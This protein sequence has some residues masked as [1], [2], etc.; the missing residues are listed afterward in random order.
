MKAARIFVLF[1]ASAAAVAQNQPAQTASALID[2][3]QVEPAQKLARLRLQEQPGDAEALRV[4]GR[5]ML[6]NGDTEGAV[7]TL[8]EAAAKQTGSAETQSRLA[9]AL[10][11]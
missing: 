4:L 9:Q 6:A 8:E 1:F 5:A 3:C 11:Q 10:I 7:K 2:A